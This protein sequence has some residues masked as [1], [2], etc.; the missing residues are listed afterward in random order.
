M[1]KRMGMNPLDAVV[2]P[3]QMT[4]TTKPKKERPKETQS[5]K[6]RVTTQLPLDLAER[7][8]NAVFWTPGLTVSDLMEEA[9]ESHLAKLEKK[10]GEAFPPRKS[11][12]KAGRPVG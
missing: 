3:P 12:L 10:R 7:V 9:L 1:G 6:G 8:R 11:P 2:P 5:L 4:K